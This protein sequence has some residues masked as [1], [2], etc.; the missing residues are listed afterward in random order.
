[1]CQY[2]VLSKNVKI[3]NDDYT[4]QTPSRIWYLLKISQKETMKASMI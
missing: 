3:N 2:F 4:V 1:M